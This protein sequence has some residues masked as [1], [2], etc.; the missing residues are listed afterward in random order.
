[1][2]VKHA[3][4]DVCISHQGEN[5]GD[6]DMLPSSGSAGLFHALALDWVHDVEAL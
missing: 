1:M 6:P 4:F 2:I 3:F 5:N